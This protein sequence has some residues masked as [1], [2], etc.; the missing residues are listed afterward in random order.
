MFHPCSKDA[1]LGAYNLVMLSHVASSVCIIF[2][3]INI[4]YYFKNFNS[5]HLKVVRFAK[6]Q[7]EWMSDKVMRSVCFGFVLML[8]LLLWACFRHGY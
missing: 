7:I 3:L 1:G 4:V 5:I 8:L 2:N 6:S